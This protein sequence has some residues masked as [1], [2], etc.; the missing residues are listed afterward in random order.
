MRDIQERADK[1]NK[2]K[3]RMD[4]KIVIINFDILLKV[5]EMVNKYYQLL[6]L[7][8]QKTWSRKGVKGHEEGKYETLKSLKNMTENRD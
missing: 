6:P 4:L 3:N 8:T 7:M 1:A 5:K 2:L